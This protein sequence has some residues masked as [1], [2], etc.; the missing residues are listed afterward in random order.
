MNAAARRIRGQ[1]LAPIMRGAGDIQQPA[2]HGIADRHADWLAG[3]LHSHAPL[4]PCRGVQRNGP[5][6]A[7]IELA[8]HF[9]RE[10]RWPVPFHDQRRVDGGQNAAAKTD[11]NDRPLHRDDGCRP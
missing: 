6:R 10:R 7:E 3:I 9:E 4:Q 11:V 1:R 8:V 5:Y 2:E